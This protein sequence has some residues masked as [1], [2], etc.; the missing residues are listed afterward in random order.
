MP[1][2]A[3]AYARFIDLCTRCG[4]CLRACPGGILVSGAGG[5][6]NVGFG[7]GACTF[8][9]DCV[10]ACEAGALATESATGRLKYR[11]TAK[12]APPNV[13]NAKAQSS[14]ERRLNNP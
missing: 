3:A 13:T 11:L 12:I 1:P 7:H 8:C 4:D 2:W 5:F 10:R 9:G 14:L 6:P